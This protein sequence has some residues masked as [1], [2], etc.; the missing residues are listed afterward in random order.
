MIP[1]ELLASTLAASRLVQL[2][3]VDAIAESLRQAWWRRWPAPMYLLDGDECPTGSMDGWE[4]VYPT[5]DG[6][7]QWFHRSGTPLG[8]LLRCPA[9]LTVHAAYAV[10][11]AARPSRLRHPL[12]LAV[13]TLTVAAAVPILGQALRFTTRDGRPKAHGSP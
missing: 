12:R 10:L 8:E 1:F 13:D 5:A 7:G 6:S 9:C 4:R 3:Q 11:I 2:L